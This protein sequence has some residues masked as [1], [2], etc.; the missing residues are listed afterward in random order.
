MN[1][2]QYNK[3]LRIEIARWIAVLPISLFFLYSSVSYTYLIIEW[4]PLP[5]PDITEGILY[6]AI[7]IY[8]G[9][10]YVYIGT[11][12]APRFRFYV[13]LILIFFI[14]VAIVIFLEYGWIVSAFSSLYLIGGIVMPKSVRQSEDKK[15]E[16]GIKAHPDDL[17]E[18]YENLKKWFGKFRSS[19]SENIFEY[20][21]PYCSKAI[22]TEMPPG[23]FAKCRNC[24]RSDIVP[25]SAQCKSLDIQDTVDD[26]S[27]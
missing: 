13:S 3:Y 19:K 22:E 6:I 24:G 16:D 12:I 15:G 23:E 14:I 26:Q 11:R 27:E 1:D 17:I 7:A 5:F 21:C 20:I 4:L 10:F 18:K 9:G 8:S 25:T 2:T